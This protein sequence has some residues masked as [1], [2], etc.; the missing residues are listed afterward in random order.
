VDVHVNR[1]DDTDKLRLCLRSKDG[2]FGVASPKLWENHHYCAEKFSGFKR[3]S[4]RVSRNI[5][6]SLQNIKR[7]ESLK[8]NLDL[9]FEDV[10]VLKL[11]KNMMLNIKRSKMFIACC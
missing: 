10:L 2:R 3:N 5:T 9:R 8:N 6:F 11:C 4:F 7:P 1:A